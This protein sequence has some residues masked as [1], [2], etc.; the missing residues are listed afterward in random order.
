MPITYTPIATQT[1]GSAASSVTFS[2]I[3]STYTDLVLVTNSGC[4]TV[5]TSIF[6]QVNGDTGSNYSTTYLYGNGTAVG[7]GRRTSQTTGAIAF[8]AAMNTGF[9]HNSIT[10]FLNYSNTTT[11]KT[12]ISRGNRASANDFP[13]AETT[14]NLWR[15][16]SAI[17]SIVVSAGA[18]FI[19]GSTFT[20]Y[21]IK[22][23]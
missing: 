5:G 23:A 17:T 2:S 6:F 8:F 1:L 3:P 7:S 4:A 20:L 19:V 9:E 10:S 14:V 21:G 18:N 15:N 22:A 16:T 11:F 12:T 13:A